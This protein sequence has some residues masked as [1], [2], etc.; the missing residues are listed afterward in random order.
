M[1][2]YMGFERLIKCFTAQLLTKTI[3]ILPVEPLAISYIRISPGK[4]QQHISQLL[5]PFRRGGGVMFVVWQ[6]PQ[7]IQL[8]LFRG[9]IWFFQSFLKQ[10]LEVARYCTVLELFNME[11]DT[12]LPHLGP[13]LM[14]NSTA[15]K[16]LQLHTAH[17]LSVHG[18]CKI[19]LPFHS[20]G[21]L[22]IF[23]E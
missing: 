12:P 15:N 20:C 14:W 21:D 3:K 6:S 23:T 5:D 22:S 13:V 2:L 18:A 10:D 19:V 7:E 8:N 9:R 11:I 1:L 16:V 17:H 4:R